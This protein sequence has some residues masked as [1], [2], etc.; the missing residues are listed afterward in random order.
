MVEAKAA[1]ATQAASPGPLEPL[2][3]AGWPVF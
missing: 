2:T 1:D 3:G